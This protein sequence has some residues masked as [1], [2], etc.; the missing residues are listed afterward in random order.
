MHNHD[1]HHIENYQK[2]IFGFW[3]YLMTDCMLFAVLF[4]TYGVLHTSTFGGPPGKELFSLPLVLAETLALLISSFTCGLAGLAGNKE[5]KNQV[6]GYLLLTFFLGLSF[7]V[8]EVSEFVHL[9][10]EGNG[11]DRSAFLSS[12]FTLVG[13]HGTHVSIGLIWMLVLMGQIYFRGVTPIT[14]KRFMCFRLF[15]HF[16]DIVWIFL[17]TVVYL[18]G[19]A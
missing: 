13:T 10:Q 6:V 4:A 2:T 17:F 5:A 9:I 1:H 12:F 19:A 15:W 7:V 18:M 14:H 16:L 3:V 11:P 8:M